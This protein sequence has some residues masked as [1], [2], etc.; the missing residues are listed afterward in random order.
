MRCEYC[1]FCG[2][3]T[4]LREIGD[5]GE[6]PYCEK[7]GRPLF[8]MFHTCVLCI[9]VNEDNEVA[10]IRQSYGDTEK[11]V[12]VAGFMK[13]GE[14]PEEAALREVKEELGLT[15]EEVCYIDSCFYAEREQLMLGML[16][17][18]KRADFRISEELLEARWST[19]REGIETVREGSIVQRFLKRVRDAAAE[20]TDI[21]GLGKMF[22]IQLD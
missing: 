22:D 3:K 21:T 13:C 1:P 15:A 17:R 7:C 5:E 16:V 11:Y 6:M 10:L 2:N 8:D 9:V 14:T 18:V 12:G 4:I 19:L 20:K